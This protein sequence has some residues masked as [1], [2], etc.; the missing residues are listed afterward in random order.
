MNTNRALTAIELSQRAGKQI[1]PKDL[2]KFSWEKSVNEKALEVF[3][4]TRNNYKK[5]IKAWA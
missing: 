5:A 3:N 1:N 2:I 4:Y